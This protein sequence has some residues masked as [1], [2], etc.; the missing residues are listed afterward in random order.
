MD[1]SIPPLTVSSFSVPSQSARPSRAVIP[2]L[3]VCARAVPVESSSTPPL[4]V[5]ASASALSPLASIPPLTVRP[6]KRTPAGTLTRNSTFTSFSRTR[7]AAALARRALVR[8]AVARVDG[9]DRDTARVLDDLDLD[10][11]RVALAALL[12][13]GHLD[14]ASRRAGRHDPAVDALDLDRLSRRDLAR[15]LELLL[16]RRD[17]RRNRR[18]QRGPKGS[19]LASCRLLRFCRN[20]P[21]LRPLADGDAARER[22]DGDRARRPSRS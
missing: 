22:L 20:R 6:T 12:D 16:R 8:R 18:Q 19:S 21:P 10:V 11:G 13:G 2:P 9:A 5:S 17:Q 15:P 4:T 1:T 7:I 14:V 3:T